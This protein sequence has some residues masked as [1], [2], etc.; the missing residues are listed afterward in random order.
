MAG[1]CVFQQNPDAFWDHHDGVFGHQDA[2]TA[3]NL[4]DRHQQPYLPRHSG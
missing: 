3:D 2:I 4:K 1:R